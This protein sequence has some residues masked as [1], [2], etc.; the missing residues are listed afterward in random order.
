[1]ITTL[2]TQANTT[3]LLSLRHCLSRMQL[4]YISP[5]LVLSLLLVLSHIRIPRIYSKSVNRMYGPLHCMD[6]CTVWTTTHRTVRTAT[7][8]LDWIKLNYSPLTY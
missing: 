4:L 6:R 7:L 2:T 8:Q 1:M 5:Y 3:L